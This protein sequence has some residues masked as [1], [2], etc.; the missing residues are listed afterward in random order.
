LFAKNKDA[1]LGVSSTKKRV[2]KAETVFGE[3]DTEINRTIKG[4]FEAK[5]KIGDKT[6]SGNLIKEVSEEDWKFIEKDKY[7][8]SYYKCVRCTK[9]CRVLK[10]DRKKH[11]CKFV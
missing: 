1:P 11:S 4:R 10:G 9:A 2:H 6:S 5:Y 8:N 7:S 3:K